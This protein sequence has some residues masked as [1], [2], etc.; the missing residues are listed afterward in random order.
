M[1]TIYTEASSSDTLA[2]HVDVEIDTASLTWNAD[3]SKATFTIQD[4]V[5]APLPDGRYTVSWADRFGAAARDRQEQP[6]YT[7]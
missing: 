2:N 1:Y 7:A 6:A 3:S 4:T 5:D